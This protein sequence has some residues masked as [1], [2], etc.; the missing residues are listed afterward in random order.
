MPPI[1]FDGKN[2]DKRFSIFNRIFVFYGT[3]FKKNFSYNSWK[4]NLLIILKHLI[5]LIL[6]PFY[7]PVILIFKI[8]NLKIIHVD[9]T[10]FG[11][12]I[13]HVDF[14]IK[15]NKLYK[16]P[17]KLILLAPHYLVVNKYLA[18]VFKKE[19]FVSESFLFYLILYPLMH[20]NL[21]SVEAWDA[22]TTNKKNTYNIVHKN[23]NLKNGSYFLNIYD[24]HIP[25]INYIKYLSEYGLNEK[26]FVCI[27]LRDPAYYNYN[28]C[29]DVEIESYISAINFLIERKIP[30]VRF[31]HKNSKSIKSLNNKFYH[32]YTVDNDV[33]KSVQYYLIKNSKFVICTQSGIYNLNSLFDVPFFLTNAI[34]VNICGVV[35]PQDRIIIKKF[36]YKNTNKFLKIHDIINKDLNTLPEF[37]ITKHNIEIVDNTNYEILDGVKEILN[38]INEGNYLNNR[39]AYNELV[40]YHPFNCTDA[41]IPRNFK[42]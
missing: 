19:V 9:F 2:W 38:N 15:Q 11:A 4:Y 16:K 36:K 24:G 21:T 18:N 33:N 7:T 40:K 29:R 6:F 35:K 14:L 13:H 39:C 32:E 8:F 17:K 41:F 23:Y 37:N 27:H 3:I 1:S 5:V 31:V 42:I 28:S 26:N 30:V 25:K 34:P 10:Q 20:Y 12:V 22:E